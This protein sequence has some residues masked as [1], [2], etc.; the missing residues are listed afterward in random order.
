MHHLSGRSKIQGKGAYASD[1]EIEALRKEL[2][3]CSRYTQS[4]IQPL[5][6]EELVQ[7]L[8]LSFVTDKSRTFQE[9]IEDTAIQEKLRSFRALMEEGGEGFLDH[10]VEVVREAKRDQKILE[11]PMEDTWDLVMRIAETKLDSGRK[12]FSSGEFHE[13]VDDFKAA[14]VQL[15]SLA[16]SRQGGEKVAGTYVKCLCNAAVA[17]YH[18]GALGNVSSLCSEAL[19]VEPC[20]PKALYWRGKSNLERG[21]CDAAFK[22]LSCAAEIAPRDANIKNEYTVAHKKLVKLEEDRQ[23]VHRQRVKRALRFKEEKET[24]L[25][26]LADRPAPIS[27]SILNCNFPSLSIRPP[28]GKEIASLRKSPIAALLEYCSKV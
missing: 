28:S 10:A 27:A 25:M 23:E 13:A 12:H 7:T 19:K 21:L 22:D 17:S 11:I 14:A 5:L 8:L 4:L 3:R 15:K 6:G 18:E 9:W 16:L 20:C 24:A 26:M 2:L 1:D